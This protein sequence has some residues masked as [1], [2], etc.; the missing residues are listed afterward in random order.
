[1]KMRNVA[2]EMKFYQRILRIEWTGILT[3]KEHLKEMEIERKHLISSRK[4]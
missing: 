2:I 3:D 1:M 4:I